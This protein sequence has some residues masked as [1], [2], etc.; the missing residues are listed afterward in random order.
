MGPCRMEPCK[1]PQPGALQNLGLEWP[2]PPPVR[3]VNPASAACDSPPMQRQYCNHA[4]DQGAHCQPELRVDRRGHVRCHA[5]RGKTRT[6]RDA[7]RPMEF[8]VRA[9]IGHTALRAQAI[10]PHLLATRRSSSLPQQE[11]LCS[12]PHDLLDESRD[13]GINDPREWEAGP[14]GRTT[15]RTATKGEDTGVLLVLLWYCDDDG[16]KGFY[17]WRAP[18]E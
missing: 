18:R 12:Q 7:A 3:S 10:H 13:F 14:E 11:T 15:A 16:R 17:F 6:A 8:G 1:R 5:R 4:L 2:P 9:A